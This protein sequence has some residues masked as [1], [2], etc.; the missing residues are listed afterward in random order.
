MADGSRGKR[1]CRMMPSLPCVLVLGGAG[2]IGSHICQAL[3][4]VGY[5]PVVYDNLVGGHRQAVQWGPLEVGDVQDGE[6]LSSVFATYRPSVVVHA[7]GLIEVGASVADPGSYYRGNVSATIQLLDTMCRHSVRRLVF[8]SSA[9]V[10][11]VTRD[12]CLREDAPIEPSSPYGR[13]KAMVEMMLR[14]WTVAHGLSWLS[15]RFFNTAGADPMGGDR[16]SASPGNP[17][18][19]PSSD[20][21][22]RRKRC[23]HHPWSGLSDPRWHRHPR[24][25]ACLRPSRSASGGDQPLVGQS[26]R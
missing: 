11:A 7:A 10:Y 12:G 17:P 16:R 14:D 22:E 4:R 13:S 26:D 18:D 24:L 25:C 20:V 19:S 2:Y 23:D 3:T 1:C 6:R 8:C 9:A 21:F 15:L 5:L